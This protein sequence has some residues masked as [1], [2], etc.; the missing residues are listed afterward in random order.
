MPWPEPNL[1]AGPDVCVNWRSFKAVLFDLDGVVTNS[2]RLHELAWK[3]VFDDILLQ[4]ANKTGVKFRPFEIELDYVKYVDGKPREDGIKA[5]LASRGFEIGRHEVDSATGLPDTKDIAAR[6][7][8]IFLK[9]LEQL[10]IEAYPGALRLIHGLRALGCRLAVISSSRNCSAVLKAARLVD[11]FDAQVDGNVAERM[12]LAGKPAPDTFL[13]AARQLQVAPREAA[14]IEDSISGVR[15]A[16]A[17]H[18]GFIVGVDRL[19]IGPQLLAHG[20]DSVVTD[21]G[22]LMPSCEQ[23]PSGDI[24]HAIPEIIRDVEARLRNNRV[25]LFLDYD[26]TLTP[27]VERPELAVLDDGTR[28]IVR[29]LARY[30]TVIIISGR[31][32]SDVAERVGIDTV[33]YAG[34]HGFEIAGP[35]AHPIRNKVGVEH[36][37]AIRSAARELHQRLD[38]IDGVIIEDKAFSVAVHYRLV[39]ETRLTEVAHAVQEV[40]AARPG[41]CIVKGKKVYE[42]RPNIKWDKGQ[43]LLWIL[44]ELGLD[45]PD[46]VPIFIGDD[47]TDEDAFKELIER[48]IG[49][50]VGEARATYARYRLSD[51]GEVREFLYRLAGALCGAAVE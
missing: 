38:V 19:K 14:I 27:I 20:A 5:F 7:N 35:K 39:D 44:Q 11:M 29:R 46:V 26:G 8:K 50:M 33:I 6:K 31:A 15:A 4:H 3:E 41:L 32:L 42:L 24:S 1:A 16:C 23:R 47:S 40:L 18:F 25:V 43:A 45:S 21:L 49:V 34:S 17:G 13:L 28:A 37:P 36:I 9:H 48:G 30:C 51:P 10:G 2:A 22:Q 12:H